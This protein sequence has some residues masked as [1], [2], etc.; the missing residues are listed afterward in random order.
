[1]NSFNK[2]LGYI[3]VF[4]LIYS[5]GST[6]YLINYNKLLPIFTMIVLSVILFRIKN[7]KLDIKNTVI[8]MLIITCILLTMVI[9]LDYDISHYIG[10]I[11]TIIL[12]YLISNIIE[13]ND[14]TEYYIN[15]I[16]FI[17]ITSLIF[18]ILGLIN[19]TLVNSFQTISLE[20]RLEYKNIYIYN[21]RYS[22]LAIFQSGYLKNNS[23]FWE[24]G[25][26]QAFLNLALIL[27]L[28]KYKFTRIKNIVLIITTILTTLST[29]GLISLGL[30]LISYVDFRID[31]KKNIFI[32]IVLI[33]FIGIVIHNKDIMFDKF[34][35][36]S[37]SYISFSHRYEGTKED[38]K[39]WSE[40]II[41]GNGYKGYNYKQLIGSANSVTATLAKYG[42][43][44]T[45]LILILNYVFIR[46]ISLN[47]FQ[48]LVFVVVF[49]MIY[50]T[51]NFLLTP[52]FL[53]LGFSSIR[54]RYK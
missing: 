51:E 27:E 11:M 16:K 24:P 23:F 17:C 54:K 33:V 18:Y 52:L 49:I 32:S 12:S 6:V 43:L 53:C 46:N 42:I 34:D 9:N 26:Y 8:I 22:P 10:I 3:L 36:N 31:R 28:K 30:I 20:G 21:Y 19:P 48:A 2:K 14:L 50:C 45:G 5:T 35:K 47:M 4:I 7:I 40:K 1:M 41:T 25:A 29:T 13:Y 39:L 15:I 38:Y 37:S 44:F